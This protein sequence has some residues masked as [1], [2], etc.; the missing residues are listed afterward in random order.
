MTYLIDGYNLLHRAYGSWLRE[1]GLERAR[2][3]LEARLE[4]FAHAEP[5]ARIVLCYDG[6]GARSTRS[7]R[8]PGLEVRFSSGGT[9]ADEL[10]L[11]L[12]RSAERAA[13]IMV[14]T[15]D[16]VDIAGRVRQ[17]GCRHRSSEEFAAEVARAIDAPRGART[18][19]EPPRISAKETDAWLR[20]FDLH[21]EDDA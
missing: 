15:S 20:E 10:I 5:D 2:E 3:Q 4:A 19:R 17:L 1:L 11:D 14:V 7:E 9:S 18:S 8:L 13:S 12:A 16:V 21:P 6:R